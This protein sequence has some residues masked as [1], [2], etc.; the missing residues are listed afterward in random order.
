MPRSDRIIL[1][2]V[3]GVLLEWE[4]HFAN[5]ML[6]KGYQ[7]KP[8]KEKI[9]SMDKRYGLTKKK[10][11]ELIKEFNNS[12]WMS[13]QTPLPESQTWVKLLHAEGS[14]FI[15]ITS[16]TRDIPAQELRKRRLQ[17]LFGGTVFENFFILDTGADKDSALAEFHGTGLWWV[18]DKPENALLGLEYG[19]R[20]L[21]VDHSYNCKFKHREILRVKDWKD[22]YKIINEKIK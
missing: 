5:W 14:T 21:L 8:G 7:Q 18:E 3:D 15:P 17:E 6:T 1:T 10:K 19:L 2:D 13:T 20:P 4:N 11:E 9:Y 16:Q 22:I 12:A